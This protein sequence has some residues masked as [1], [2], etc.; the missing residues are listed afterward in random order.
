MQPGRTCTVSMGRLA[1]N[2]TNW[3]LR[4]DIARARSEA[5]HVNTREDACKGS[6]EV[7]PFMYSSALESYS[8]TRPV[9]H[10]AGRPALQFPTLAVCAVNEPS[11]F[12]SVGGFQQLWIPLELLAD[13][14]GDVAQVVGFGQPAGILDR[15][16]SGRVGSRPSAV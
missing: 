10:R 4:F 11:R 15:S 12:G 9:L 3:M 13:A 8:E 2:G 7:D 6:P 5:V 1:K 16:C 14:V